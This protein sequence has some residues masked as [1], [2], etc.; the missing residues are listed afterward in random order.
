MT[1]GLQ[2]RLSIV[3]SI[4]I[5]KELFSS[6][7]AFALL[8]DAATD[9]V[10]LINDLL[11][12]LSSSCK[13]ISIMGDYGEKFREALLDFLVEDGRVAIPFF[14]HSEVSDAIATFLGGDL[15]IDDAYERLFFSLSEE[16]RSD[17]ESSVVKAVYGF[18]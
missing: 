18:R 7:G 11:N 15:P 2:S 9:N 8:V 13:F 3:G 14:S 16:I 6:S 4:G 17:S 12:S 10:E 5:I 1:I